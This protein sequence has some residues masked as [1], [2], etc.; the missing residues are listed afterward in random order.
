MK[1]IIDKNRL[2]N[3]KGMTLLEVVIAIALLVT[4]MLAI[5]QM[6]IGA[7]QGNSA[8]NRISQAIT[9]ASD[10]M[11]KLINMPMTSPDLTAGDHPEVDKP[12]IVDG[13]NV[14]WKVTDDPIG[15]SKAIRVTVQWK[16]HLGKTKQSSLDY[17]KGGD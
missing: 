17:V 12:V 15:G 11:E 7:I 10:R 3:E 1:K 13:F 16:D 6:Q 14:G 5:A 2:F 8:A 9:V 4:G